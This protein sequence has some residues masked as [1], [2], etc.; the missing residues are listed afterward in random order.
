MQIQSH[1]QY[2]CA[3]K[4]IPLIA[5]QECGPVSAGFFKEKLGTDWEFFAEETEDP[6]AT[7]WDT[8]VAFGLGKA[9]AQGCDRG[10]HVTRLSTSMSYRTW[11]V[12]WARTSRMSQPQRGIAPR[13]RFF[14]RFPEPLCHLKNTCLCIRCCR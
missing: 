7:F 12:G 2:L 3:N 13:N 9:V 4:A 1:I 11:C 14:Y 6:V 5:L 8:K 10:E